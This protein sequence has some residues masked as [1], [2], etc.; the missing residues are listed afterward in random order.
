MCDLPIHVQT[1][2][3][4]FAVCRNNQM[5]FGQKLEYLNR[6]PVYTFEFACYTETPEAEV[7]HHVEQRY[8]I[9]LSRVLR[10]M[11]LPGNFPKCR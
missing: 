10:A 2:I 1:K 3:F 6:T 11:N 9:K 8:C 4:S 5:L 7:Y